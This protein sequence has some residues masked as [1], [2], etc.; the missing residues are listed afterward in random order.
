MQHRKF[1]HKTSGKPYTLI[2]IANEA[3]TRPDFVKQAVYLDADGNVWSRPL[4]EFEEKFIELT[5]QAE[6]VSTELIKLYQELHQAVRQ[7]LRFNG[8]DKAKAEAAFRAL[9]HASFQVTL[10]LERDQEDD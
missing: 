10:Y 8:V 1:I 5:P 3:A 7:F 9:T 4:A 2:Q 6:S